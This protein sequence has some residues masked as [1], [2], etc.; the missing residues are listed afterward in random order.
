MSSMFEDLINAV[1]LRAVA[2]FAGFLLVVLVP[3]LWY[4]NK[5]TGRSMRDM[6]AV[7]GAGV[8]FIL[9]MMPAIILFHDRLNSPNRRARRLADDVFVAAY[10]LVAIVLS[11]AF[12]KLA[13]QRTRKK[14]EHEGEAS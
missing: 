3:G 1:D 10:T 7:L 13:K 9:L 12:N 14:S 11:W 6:L 5:T 2:I 4:V 8:V